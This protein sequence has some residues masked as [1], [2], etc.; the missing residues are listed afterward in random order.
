MSI[1]TRWAPLGGFA[2][3]PDPSAEAEREIGVAVRE[4]EADEA[5]DGVEAAAGRPILFRS[6]VFLDGVGW[7][8]TAAEEG[9]GDAEG[10]AEGDVEG[11]EGAGRCEADTVAALRAVKTMSSGEGVLNLNEAS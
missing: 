6:W 7:A 1:L 2:A 5:G 3:G 8:N 10:D 11:T 9:A 4:E